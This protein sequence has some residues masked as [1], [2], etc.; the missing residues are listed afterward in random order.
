MLFGIKNAIAEEKM[1]NITLEAKISMDDDYIRDKF[2]AEEDEEDINKNEEEF[3]DT[4]EDDPELAAL[5]EKIPEYDGD[6]TDEE[7][8]ELQENF[9]PEE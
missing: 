1:D 2:L 9:I 3:L 8:E 6:I 4:I 7:L 5:I